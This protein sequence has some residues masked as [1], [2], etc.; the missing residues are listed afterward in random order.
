MSSVN[1]LK[2]TANVQALS[3]QGEAALTPRAA[4]GSGALLVA[5]GV[6]AGAFGAH[7]L[8]DVVTADR[9]ATF[10]T[11]V[12]YQIYAGLGLLL[13]G[14]AGHIGRGAPRAALAVLAGAVVFSLSLYLLVAGAPS[15]FGMIAP[16]GGALMIGGWLTAA[17]RFLKE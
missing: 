17:W 11:G 6:A 8:Q 9:L 1:E 2:A 15:F 3:R 14:L 13:L 12:R 10:E 5:L 16:I 7:T 4:A